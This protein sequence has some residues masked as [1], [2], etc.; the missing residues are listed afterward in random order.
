MKIMKI[1]ALLVLLAAPASGF[2]FEDTNIVT[3]GDWSTPVAGF[4]DATTLRG[5][6][7]P[8]IRGRLLLVESPKDH[9]LALYL[10]LQECA[11]AWGNPTEIYCNLSPGR[12]CRLEFRDPA[13]RPLPLHGGAFGGG[14]PGA[15]WISLPCDATVRLRL[16]AF[17]GFSYASTN[18]YVV[19]GTFT[20]DP[21]ADHPGLEVWQGTL[22]LP[23]L[24]VPVPKP[25]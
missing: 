15:N 3:G 22:T 2:A 25:K 17:A 9:D 18:D 1:L 20:A 24:K 13:G 19:A 10:E 6:H 11:G 5:A 7:H 12:G 4:Q 8:V 16:S 14:M 23:P 21:P